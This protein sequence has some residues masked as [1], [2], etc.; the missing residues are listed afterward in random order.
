M[1]LSLNVVIAQCE[2]PDS[3]LLS[4]GAAEREQ[5]KGHPG[6]PGVLS[7]GKRSVAQPN[8]EGTPG[9]ICCHEGDEQR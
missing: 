5:Y 7:S 9:D 6:V 4:I 8:G 3:D 1:G 2:I